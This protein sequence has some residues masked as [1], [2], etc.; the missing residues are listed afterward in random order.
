MTDEF[1]ILDVDDEE[2]KKPIE[3]FEFSPEYTRNRNHSYLWINS[4]SNQDVEQM[5]V[6]NKIK[7]LLPVMISSED[8]GTKYRYEITSLIP[9]THWIKKKSVG[10]EEIRIVLNSIYHCSEAIEEFFLELESLVLIP[11][12][13]FIDEKDLQCYFLFLDGYR[14]DFTVALKQVVQF[15]LENINDNKRRETRCVYDIYETGT[16]NW[17]MGLASTMAIVF[18][19]FV[20]ILTIIQNVLTKGKEEK[21]HVNKKAKNN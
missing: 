6:H 17:E 13:I 2:E 5:L 16:M 12:Y 19:I 3:D 14:V 4:A 7:G 1:D 9:L 15:L 20:V 8:G 10:I 18:T 11:E 21:K